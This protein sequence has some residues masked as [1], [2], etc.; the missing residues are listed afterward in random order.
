M[1]CTVLS[2]MYG[3]LG[4]G[5]HRRIASVRAAAGALCTRSSSKRSVMPPGPRSDARSAD[6]WRDREQC[7]YCP[8][9]DRSK[10]FTECSDVVASVACSLSLLLCGV[11]A[12]VEERETD[13]CRRL[14]L[15][16]CT[17]AESES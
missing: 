10:N 1:Y 11:V 4:L 6:E 15:P 2:Y 7:T 9:L 3:V 5:L 16:G 13:R 17:I 12:R 8:V 14:Q